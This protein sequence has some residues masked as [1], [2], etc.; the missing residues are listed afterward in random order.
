MLPLLPAVVEEIRSLT[1][2]FDSGLLFPSLKDPA[3]PYAFRTSWEKALKAAEINDFRF[4]DLRHS[5]A[6][7]L[8]MDGATLLEIADV[9]GHKTLAMVKRYS[10]L[11]SDHKRKVV[12]GTFS[13][14]LG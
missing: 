12:E 1:T 10:H 14:K 9:L 11:S 3:K 5:C 2:P 4:H 7:Y 6:S 13:D 8:A